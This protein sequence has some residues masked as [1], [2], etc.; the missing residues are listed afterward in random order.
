MSGVFVVVKLIYL[1]F[2]GHIDVI[3]DVVVMD[4]F[5]TDSDGQTKKEFNDNFPDVPVLKDI[6][7]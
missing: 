7:L 1:T 4:G 6:Y 3:W 2:I 5:C